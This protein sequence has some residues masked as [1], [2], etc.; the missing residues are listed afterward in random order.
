MSFYQNHCSYS[1]IIHEIDYIFLNFTCKSMKNF[2]YN[3]KEQMKKK[4][5]EKWKKK[6]TLKISVYN[7]YILFLTKKIKPFS[8][9]ISLQAIF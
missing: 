3:K 2:L 9:I 8:K 7:L 4:K 6:Q 1:F 5:R